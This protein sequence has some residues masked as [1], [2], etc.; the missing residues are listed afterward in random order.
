MK[1]LVLNIPSWWST[2]QLQQFPSEST[3][4][5]GDDATL[6]IINICT[7]VPTADAVS[8]P[9]GRCDAIVILTVCCQV[10]GQVCF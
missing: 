5:E 2:R 8:Q 10:V 1:V 3:F 6:R 7:P 9:M 4:P